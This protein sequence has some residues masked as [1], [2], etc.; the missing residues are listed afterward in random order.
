MRKYAT[1]LELGA[2]IIAQEEE[3]AKLAKKRAKQKGEQKTLWDVCYDL[4]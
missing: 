1:I 3:E 4:H 2:A